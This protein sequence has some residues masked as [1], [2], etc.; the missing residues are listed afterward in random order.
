MLLSAL[1]ADAGV[2]AHRELA[3][4]HLL[5]WCQYCDPNFLTPP[6]VKLLALKLEA[7]E[8]GE[9]KRLL[10][11]EPPR[12][13]K[14][15]LITKRFPGWFLGRN[16]DKRVIQASHGAELADEFGRFVRNSFEEHGR[17][18]F[19]ETVADDSSAANRWDIAGRRGGL[20]ATGVGGSLTG[21]GANLLVIDDPVKDAKE[22]DSALLRKRVWDWY[23]SV[24]RTRLEPWGAIVI[25]LTRWHD[26]DLAGRLL[27]QD[28]K[29][30]GEGW[31]VL[32]LP[33]L[34]EDDD[35]IGREPGEA[36]WPERFPKE[37]LEKTR[38]IVGSR[39]WSSLYQQN[40]TPDSGEVFDTR[41][42]RFYDDLPDDLDLSIQS[43]DLTFDDDEGNDYSV[44][45]VW[46]VKGLDRYLIHQIKAR[47]DAPAQMRGIRLLAEMYP[48]A[49]GKYIEKAAN[50][51][52]VIKLLRNEIEG[53][54]PV[55]V[56]GGPGKRVRARAVTP[57]FE[58]GHVH[59]PN[60]D[61]VPWVAGLIAEM[62]TFPRGK[63]D[64][65][66]DA[67]T[68]ALSHMPAA[69]PSFPSAKDDDKPD[70]VEGKHANLRTEG[71]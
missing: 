38:I 17:D 69:A 55:K 63:H 52:A 6:H 18:V 28:R 41:Q 8:R 32:S 30:E 5:D 22:V 42:I 45:Q 64:D 21:R 11:F 27:E 19:G 4:R 1:P 62:A 20:V 51:A 13:G 43:W 9:I 23:I 40:P 58:S 33:A 15:E 70:M 39:V 14:S 44:G 47:M 16:P 35:P 60:P 59:F 61:R 29:G 54:V 71:F 26:D 53:M 3:R 12:H 37:E 36:L 25:V 65:Q 34:A 24:A 10:V 2:Q 68:Q 50:G 49:I 31:E 56:S 48:E 66:I 57:L 67:M 7:V 46:G